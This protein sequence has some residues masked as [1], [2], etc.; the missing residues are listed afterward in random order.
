[1]KNRLYSLLLTSI[2]I[3]SSTTIVY[4]SSLQPSA[5]PI[6][7]NE[8]NIVEM[9]QQIDEDLVFYYHDN[10]MKFGPRYT[11]T[12]NC[13]LAGQYIYNEFEEM[14]LDTTVHE[15][16]YD[17][18]ESRN[19]VGTLQGSDPSSNAIFIMSA[20][21][22]CTPGSL[23]AD[24]DGSGV[25]AVLATAKIMSQY[26]FNHTI[27]FITFSGEEVGTYGSFTYARDAY[28]R[29]DNIVAVIN[30]DMVGYANTAKGGRILRFHCPQ[31]SVWIS[32]FSITVAEKYM[33]LIDMAVEMRP[34]YVG[35]DHQAF[36]DYGYDG[37][38]IAHHDGYPWANTPEDT[39]DHLNW[40]YQTKATKLLLAIMAEIAI[41]PIDVQVVLTS[42]YEG[43][44]YFFNR[45]II[46]LSLGKQWYK[47]RRGMTVVLGRAVASAEVYTNEEIEYV[48]FCIDDNFMYFDSDPP[49]EWKIQG[50]HSPP[51]GKIK[52]KV[53]AYTT[54]GKVATDEMDIRIFTLSCQYGRW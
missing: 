13:T 37:V 20:H 48:V 28:E 34:N 24:D 2:L 45:P 51:I 3:F 22:D 15:W 10:L 43:Y 35:A 30:A 44:G 52:L 36:I 54:S 18:F 9:V 25:A 1:M 42:P 23:G 50:K 27:R 4:S 49:Y 40:T 8:T 11:G 46:P 17:G 41:K 5:L 47:G 12:I 6:I 7:A 14:G 31:R 16:K 26:S 33:D 21:Y 39:P 19:V 29:G 38:W 53:Y 32:E